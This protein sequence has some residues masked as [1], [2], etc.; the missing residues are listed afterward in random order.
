MLF[1]SACVSLC[2][3]LGSALTLRL[4]A[5]V[6]RTAADTSQVTDDDTFVVDGAALR[7]A[8][9]NSLGDALLGKIPGLTVQTSSGAFGALP[10]VQL[11]GLS[12]W[13]GSSNPL[14]LVDGVPLT[15]TL[16]NGDPLRTRN[17]I[18][19]TWTRLTDFPVADIERVV[20]IRG[21]A[22]AVRYGPR[23]MSGA[24]VIETR[25]PAR[26]I[27]LAVQ[28]RVSTAAPGEQ[29]EARR[30]GLDE[31][32]ASPPFGP[33]F[34]PIET[35]DAREAS[36]QSCRAYCDHEALVF[37]GSRVSVQSQARLEAGTT[38]TRLGLSMQG[39][40]TALPVRGSADDMAGGRAVLQQ[41]FGSRG[42]IRVSQ[43][44]QRTS[45]NHPL[46]DGSG[47]SANGTFGVAAVP[48]WL[49]PHGLPGAFTDTSLLWSNPVFL[50]NG[51][52]VPRQL[53]QSVSQ[54]AL[55]LTLLRSS[56][57]EVSVHGVAGLHRLSQRDEV[58]MTTVDIAPFGNLG[59]RNVAADLREES[60]EGWMSIR[61]DI[62]KSRLL[63]SG[64]ASHQAWTRRAS[65]LTRG[66]GSEIASSALGRYQHGGWWAASDL[67]LGRERARIR[68]GA[69][70]DRAQTLPASEPGL[71]S[72]M[73]SGSLRFVSRPSGYLA[74][75]V[76]A[77][78]VESHVEALSGA[79]RE[80][81][82]WREQRRDL[83]SGLLL[84]L[85]NGRTEL[86]VTLYQQT[87]PNAT[88]QPVSGA[89]PGTRFDAV[90]TLQNRGVEGRLQFSVV[91][92][93][94]SWWRLTTL[95][96][97]SRASFLWTAPFTPLQNSAGAPGTWQF[98]APGRSPTAIWEIRDSD[99]VYLGDALPALVFSQS[100]DMRNGGW[101]LTA[102]LD[103]ELGGTVVNSV[104]YARDLARVAPLRDGGATRADS[105]LAGAP[106]YAQSGRYWALREVVLSRDLGGSR[107]P[108][109]SGSRLELSGR[110]LLVFSPLEGYDPSS[111]PFGPV[112]TRGI[113]RNAF[114]R[115][116]T[117]SLSLVLGL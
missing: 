113:T 61:Q 33:A 112:T 26:G 12:S 38:H 65:D 46:Q 94:S 8:S 109:P 72:W 85:Q 28:Q 101:R 20:V 111:R 40:R 32:M 6:V 50:V 77:G 66:G 86:A 11:R 39:R 110:N 54:G 107:G 68:L 58:N 89:P 67:R 9:A 63:L 1:R 64:G 74:L 95:A 117:V 51:V 100:T 59:T 7:R 56:R 34:S 114:P 30:F 42:G 96:G 15:L 31:A 81:S 43:L 13:L 27:H 41:T 115:L 76:A 45:G 98:I 92:R 60:A 14:V 55:D 36:W 2:L 75:H 88:A 25:R 70:G 99:P 57:R 91:E 18:E 104:Q 80:L 105:A 53:S 48:T 24:I 73:A 3:C 49:N 83:E 44:F 4:P 5:Q 62:A 29:L 103:G 35:A 17:T 93:A 69:R 47:P 87:I 37:G 82:A 106:V 22:A 10:S 78:Q 16:V 84:A 79:A 90:G 52:P 97:M 71:L 23:A 116:R 21:A 19:A 102:Q 108:L